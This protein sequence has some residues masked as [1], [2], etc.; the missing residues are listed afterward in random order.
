MNN[1]SQ[2]HQGC[3]D[4]CFPQALGDVSPAIC[5]HFP[6][7][8]K[9]LQEADFHWDPELLPSINSNT[10]LFQMYKCQILVIVNSS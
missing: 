8:M 3:A 9:Y 5:V 1:Y 10:V 2:P 7:A 6:S 4:Q